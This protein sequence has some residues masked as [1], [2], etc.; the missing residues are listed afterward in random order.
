[1]YPAC[2]MRVTCLDLKSEPPINVKETDTR[3]CYDLI[4]QTV[5]GHNLCGA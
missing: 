1:M 2:E 3:I 4:Q 5:P